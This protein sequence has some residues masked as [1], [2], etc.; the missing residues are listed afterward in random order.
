M[1][2]LRHRSTNVT[3]FCLLSRKYPGWHHEQGAELQTYH[4]L[5]GK[6]M[7]EK[8]DLFH[9]FGQCSPYLLTIK[10]CQMSHQKFQNKPYANPEI[11]KAPA[12]TDPKIDPVRVW[13]A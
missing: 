9:P 8:S 5:S 13:H 4:H 6:P 3:E 2:Y 1:Q 10:A 12:E 7:I 11:G